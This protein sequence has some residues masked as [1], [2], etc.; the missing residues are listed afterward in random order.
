[1]K[2]FS[3]KNGFLMVV[4]YV[5]FFA[6]ITSN[7]SLNACNTTDQPLDIRSA[8]SINYKLDL[9]TTW[10]GSNHDF[11]CD[12]ALDGSGN[13]YITGYTKSFGAGNYDAF[14][15]KYDSS[16]KSL[17][18]ITWGTDKGDSGTKIALDSSGNIY[19]V[20]ETNS[21]GAGGS[22]AFIAKYDSSG[23][24]LLNITWGGRNSDF[25]KSFFLDDSGNIY[26][27]GDTN[28]FGAGNYD[29]FIAKYD[30]S[31]KSLLNITWGG[32]NSDYGTGIALDVA[33]N[34]YITGRTTSF[35]VGDENA[36]IA[37]YDSSGNSLLNITYGG[38]NIDR[39]LDIALDDTENI[40]ITGESNSFGVGNFDAFISKYDT[41]GKSLLNITWGGTGYD[42]GKSFFLDDSGNIYITG[43]TTSF[44][45]G[46]Y[47]AFIAKFD[48]SGKSLLNITWGGS[49]SDYGTGIVLDDAGNIYITGR[50]NSFGAGNY[51]A[52]IAKYNA[53][54]SGIVFLDSNDDDDNDDDD[55]GESVPFGNFYLIFSLLAIIALVII[56]KRKMNTNKR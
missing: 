33:G 4:F 31:G 27:T 7:V 12:I 30:S 24:S 44:G 11:G 5:C 45:A 34:I 20:G 10:G 48:S 50:T 22:D 55:D 54:Y 43:Y 18:N 6:L 15:A 47:D 37:K 40:Y 42:F 17:L 41:S 23:K 51:D 36:F 52:F 38:S 49:N 13:I 9:I 16:G 2:A 35:G 25:G 46:N 39:G 8:T 26:I 32:S 56:Y 21:F 29:A 28:S 53:P 1:M 14:I 3:T 19:M